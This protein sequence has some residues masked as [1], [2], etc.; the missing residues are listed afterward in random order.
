MSATNAF[1]CGAIGSATCIALW[2]ST[3]WPMRAIFKIAMLEMISVP[4]PPPQKHG[5]SSVSRMDAALFGVKRRDGDCAGPRS[6]YDGEQRVCRAG[7][8]RSLG[9]II[10]AMKESLNQYNGGCGVLY[11]VR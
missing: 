10:W 5:A 11:E 2:R 9:A 6:I 8:M 1:M 7:M 3:G 4:G